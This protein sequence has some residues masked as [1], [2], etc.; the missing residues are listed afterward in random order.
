MNDIP[1]M[2]Q[3]EDEGRGTGNRYRAP[4]LEKGLDVIELLVSIAT[5]DLFLQWSPGAEEGS[6]D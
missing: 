4:A 2:P 3:G 5:S 6:D 1:G